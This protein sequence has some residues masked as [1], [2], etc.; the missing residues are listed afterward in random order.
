MAALR[1]PFSRDVSDSGF[2]GMTAFAR[3]ALP[4]GLQ[5]YR[6]KTTRRVPAGC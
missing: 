5:G 1:N 2:D 3:A 6:D 4:G